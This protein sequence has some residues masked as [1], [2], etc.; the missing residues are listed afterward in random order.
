MESD[1]ST[2]GALS[3]A[4]RES[5]LRYTTVIARGSVDTDGVDTDEAGRFVFP[6]RAAHR[7]N[8][9]WHL[10]FG[11]SVRFTAHHG[12]LDVLIAA[13]EVLIGPSGGVIATHVAGD[14]P[15]LRALAELDPAAPEADRDGETWRSIPARLASAGEEHFG[16]VYRAGA[17]MA[18]VSMRWEPLNS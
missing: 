17:E 9:E 2:R 10:S 6:L 3:W 12:F 7:E 14:E 16:N 18:P 5:F 15:S 13:P 1:S 11:G 4:I 8:G